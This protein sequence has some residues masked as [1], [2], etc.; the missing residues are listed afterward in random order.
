MWIGLTNEPTNWQIRILT[1]ENDELKYYPS[2]RLAY[3]V[4]GSRLNIVY[5]SAI[6]TTED[7]CFDTVRVWSA[8]YSHVMD[9]CKICIPG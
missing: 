5:E 1:D 9:V 4:L 6:C 2:A 7:E 8:D 3:A